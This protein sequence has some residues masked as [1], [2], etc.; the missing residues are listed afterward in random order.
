M[1]KLLLLQG[2]N[3]ASQLSIFVFALVIRLVWHAL[4]IFPYESA[5]DFSRYDT[6]SSN[7]LQGNFDLDAGLFITAPLFSYV[8]AGFK[9]LF[10]QNAITALGSVQSVLSAVSVVFLAASAGI[11][12]KQRSISVLAGFIYAIYAPSLYYVYLPGQESLFQS[13]FVIS[14]Y[15]L[16]LYFKRN[17]TV[18]IACFSLVFTFAMLTKSHVILALPVLTV[19]IL[20]SPLSISKVV[21]IRHCS[22]M[23]SIVLLL[24]AP[25]GLYNLHRHGTYVIAS[26]GFGGHFLTGH[27][28][29]FY[30]W[31]INTP[32][33]NSPE[34]KRLKSI[35][36]WQVFNKLRPA[37]IEAKTNK[38]KQSIWLK[39]GIKWCLNN[40][41]KTLELMLF[42]LKNHFTAGYSGAFYGLGHRLGLYIFTV[43]I[44]IFGYCGMFMSL[45]SNISKHAPGLIVFLSMIV[46][47]TIF[48]SQTRFRVVTLEPIYI[49][50]ASAFVVQSFRRLIAPRSQSPSSA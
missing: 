9:Y 16:C 10:N 37:V 8:F 36:N 31:V 15:Y 2:L 49:V 44:L 33:R 24:T 32:P 48:Y 1:K 50:Y 3:P 45:R 47:V 34:F 35:M 40:P 17:K 4:K 19:F 13:L 30:E 38:D 39:A 6:F 11:L 25:Y 46:F 7:I 27:N 12:F 43:P 21:R 29:D 5:S 14:F 28:D 20:M 18:D 23:L 26:S 22:I 42:N 41:Y